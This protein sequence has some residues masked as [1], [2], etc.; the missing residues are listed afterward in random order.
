MVVRMLVA[1][2]VA[3]LGRSSDDRLLSKRR[4]R[5]SDCSIPQEHGSRLLR[6]RKC[7]DSCLSIMI[8]LGI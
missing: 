1:M 8:A 6:Q 5:I 4:T 3:S 2:A 7:I